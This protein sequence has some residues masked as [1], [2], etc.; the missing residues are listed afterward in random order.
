PRAAASSGDGAS[1]VETP[2]QQTC[3]PVLL[4]LNDSEDWLMRTLDDGLHEIPP[5]TDMDDDCVGLSDQVEQGIH[6]TEMP[7]L[8][9]AH[10]AIPT[11][12]PYAVAGA[13]ILNP[14]EPDDHVFFSQL[15]GSGNALR[16]G[17]SSRSV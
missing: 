10:N 16:P 4:E 9:N 6:A 15:F 5:D 14:G 3:E 13:G 2:T 7:T 8:T 17:D 1:P 12:P 11:A